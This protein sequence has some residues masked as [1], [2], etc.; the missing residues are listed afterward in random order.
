VRSVRAPSSAAAI[1]IGS[2]GQ[3]LKRPSV[4]A[5]GSSATPKRS[6]IS[7]PATVVSV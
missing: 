6:A 5:S 7:R 4:A 1:A 3:T 2:V